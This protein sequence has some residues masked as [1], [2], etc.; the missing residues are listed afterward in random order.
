MVGAPLAET[1]AAPAPDA[2]DHLARA[3]AIF[4]DMRKAYAAG[5]FARYG[6]LLQ[7]LGRALTP[8]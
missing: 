1:V 2:V 8:P 5:D 6:E 4:E 3:R 7:D